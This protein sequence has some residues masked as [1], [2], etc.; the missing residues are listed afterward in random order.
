MG[1]LEDLF[2]ETNLQRFCELQRLATEMPSYKGG[3][4][5]ITGDGVKGQITL[6]VGIVNLLGT[7]PEE[8]IDSERLFDSAYIRSLPINPNLRPVEIERWL[9][10]HLSQAG[11]VEVKE[12][13]LIYRRTKV[14]DNAVYKYQPKTQTQK[15]EQ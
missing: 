4:A 5:I 14:A 9:Q 11:L 1:T 13:T 15:G 12:G 3:D 6:G 2:E 8:G 10:V 7:M